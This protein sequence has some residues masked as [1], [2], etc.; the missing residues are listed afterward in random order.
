MPC[1]ERRARRLL[2]MGKA[3]L[4]RFIPFAVRL[5]NK[6]NA[7]SEGRELTLK[8]RPGSETTGF[9]IVREDGDST[10]V[11]FLGELIH[12][13]RGI[14]RGLYKRREL[15]HQRRRKLRYRPRRRNRARVRGWRPP[16]IRHRIETIL[17]WVRRLSRLAPITKIVAEL[18]SSD[19]DEAMVG[20]AVQRRTKSRGSKK[21]SLREKLYKKWGKKCVYCDAIGVPL[22]LDHVIPRSHG[23]SDRPSNLVPACCDCNR[24]KGDRS[25]QD[26]LKNKP[27]LLAR[28]LSELKRPMSDAAALF[29]MRP[30]L[31]E[32]LERCTPSLNISVTDQRKDNLARLR[33]PERPALEAACVGRTH[34]LIGWNQRVLQIKCMGRG[35]YRRTGNFVRGRKRGDHRS[36]QIFGERKIKYG[37]Q[38]GDIV[39]A[40]I[41]NGK[42]KGIHRGRATVFSSGRIRISTEHGDFYTTHSRCRLIQRSDGYSY[43]YQRI[44]EAE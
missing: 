24:D 39:K 27:L 44:S 28:L 37:F 2:E 8:I 31:R 12:R 23:G 25:L 7:S 42:N 38:T 33:L 32:A 29:L 36:R 3:I 17:T 22:E 41:P 43:S 1:S 21:T 40:E 34:A 18:E 4:H 11:I 13:A 9:A 30:V 15:R 26:F 6:S 14:S 20:I 19:P 5:K 35:S 16:S 10:H